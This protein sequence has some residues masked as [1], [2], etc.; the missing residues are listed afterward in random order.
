MLFTTYL[1]TSMGT[2]DGKWRHGTDQCSHATHL[3]RFSRTMRSVRHRHAI[4][5]PDL[6]VHN[7]FASG[8]KVGSCE[9]EIHMDTDDRVRFEVAIS[10][11][12]TLHGVQNKTRKDNRL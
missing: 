2:V 9:K 10:K 1:G 3:C 4:A 11:A 5:D 12:V 7:D 8:L 6:V